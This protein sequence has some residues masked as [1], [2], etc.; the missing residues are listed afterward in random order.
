MTIEQTKKVSSLTQKI[1]GNHRYGSLIGKSPGIHKI[2]QLLETIKESDSTVLITGETGTGKELIAN[3]IHYNSPRKN[4]PLISV[5]CA[6]IPKELME[7]EFFGHVKGAY[8]GAI[9]SKQGYFEEADG[10]TLFLDEIGEMDRDIQVKLLRVLERKEIIRVGNSSSTRIDVRLI[11][12]TNKDLQ[13]EVR[14]GRF[15]EDL[16]YRIYV[17]PIHI[18]PLRKRREDIPLLIDNFVS[19]FQSKG[20]KEI[21][22]FTEKEMEEMRA[23]QS[24][25]IRFLGKTGFA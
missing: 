1:R 8:T 17:I 19:C 3:T 7:R 11:A 23:Q 14:E 4:S 20:N 9:T 5:N 21:L 18:P 10:G 15:R 6:A 16:Y 25:Y 12:A 13:K 22:P 24:D 2:F